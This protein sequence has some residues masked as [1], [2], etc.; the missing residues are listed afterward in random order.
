MRL[1]YQGI[2][3]LPWSLPPGRFPAAESRCPGKS[4][5]WAPCHRQRGAVNYGSRIAGGNGAEHPGEPAPGITAA[6]TPSL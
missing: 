1:S 6:E 5:P 2:T 4:G 3:L